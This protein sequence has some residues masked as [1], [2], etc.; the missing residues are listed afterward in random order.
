MIRSLAARHDAVRTPEPAISW[1]QAMK[2]AIRTETDLRDRLGLPQRSLQNQGFTK[3]G[4]KTEVGTTTDMADSSQQFPVFVPLEFLSRMRAG[5]SM[6]P[7]LLQV[8][9]VDAENERVEGFTTDPVG[10]V[11]AASSSLE[12]GILQKY[13]GRALLIAHQ[14][15]GVHCRYCFRRHFPYQVAAADRHTWDAAIRQLANDRSIDEVILSG[16]DPLLLTD[17]ALRTLV[18]MIAEITHVKRLRVHT[19]MPVVIPQRVTGPLL[20][21]LNGTRLT[22]WMVIHMNHPNELDEATRQALTKFVDHGIPVLNQAVLLKGV[23]DRIEVLKEL[24]RELIDLRVQ[25]YYLHQLDRVSGGAHFEVPEAEGLAI[26]DELRKRLPGY[27]VPTYVREEVGKPS[28]T[29]I[30][31]C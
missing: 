2:L 15:C 29:R 22:P 8:L 18:N 4:S 24:C 1:Q 27:A 9:P 11:F 21:T 25:P 5:D 10:E 14:A 3:S 31:N 30:T 7:L 26:V 13:Q 17:P 16:G 23:N 20:E 6:D 28:K 12:A 19:R